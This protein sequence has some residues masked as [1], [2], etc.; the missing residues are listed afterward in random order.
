MTGDGKPKK[1]RLRL[2]GAIFSLISLAVL[3]YVLIIL[4]SGEKLDF[5]RIT[6]LFRSRTPEVSVDEFYFDVG[7]D[8]VFA[9]LGEALAAAGS[10]GIQVLDKS[11]A[12]TLRDSFRMSAPAI[13][14][15]S[16]HALAYD[17][18]GISLRVFGASKVTAS[19]EATGDIVS[20]AINKNGWFCVC[21][22]ESG[23]F[24]SFVTVYDGKS[25]EVYKVSLS[26]GYALSAEVSPDNKRMA[27]LSLTEA[28][29]RISFYDLSR[30]GEAGSYELPGGLMLDM[31]YLSGDKVLAV[32]MDA[33][34]TVGTDGTASQLFNY[35]GRRLGGYD[36]SDE[37]LTLH[38]LDYGVGYQG[39]LIT[40]S[41][42]GKLL[43]EYPTDSGIIS[44][45]SSGGYLSVLRNDGLFFFDKEFGEYPPI[46]ESPS[47]AGATVVLAIS[48]GALAAGDHSAV[49]IGYERSAGH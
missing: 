40:L 37:F 6:G 9:D 10:L 34:I 30:D 13:S 43:G 14:V 33:L 35:S 25:R 32:T 18:G 20:A 27:V 1:K 48:G 4:I 39:R 47:A 49:F 46:A 2:V 12:E 28:G 45:S 16:G 22:Q 26:S 8:R 15:S 42:G 7:H 5:S 38:L 29:G 3:T 44:M 11:G 41:T 24:K 23:A 31:R 36:L 17:I 19:I 21:T